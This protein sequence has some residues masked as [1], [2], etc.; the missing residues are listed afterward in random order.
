MYIY[1]DAYDLLLKG[2][3][4]HTQEGKK[5]MPRANKGEHST[6]SASVF[7]IQTKTVLAINPIPTKP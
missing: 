1:M 6:V 7:Q 5:E 3:Q 2:G 4:K